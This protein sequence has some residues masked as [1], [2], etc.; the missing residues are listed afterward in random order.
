MAGEEVE[1]NG[2]LSNPR[3][4]DELLDLHLCSDEIL[5]LLELK[6]RSLGRRR[7]DR[8]TRRGL[9][10]RQAPIVSTV[11]RVLVDGEPMALRD[12][13]LGCMRLL[14]ADVSYRALKSGLSEHQ[15]CKRPVIVR[16]SRG[17]Y[18]LS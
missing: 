15:R 18:R 9:G 17:Y 5:K 14:G 16:V 1:H 3:V 2:A 4:T 7:A 12:I 13:H 10:P 6:Q 11:K 8:S